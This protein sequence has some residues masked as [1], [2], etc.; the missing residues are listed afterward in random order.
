MKRKLSALLA[1][2]L[3]VV[4]VFP[5]AVFVGAEE[6]A[7]TAKSGDKLVASGDTIQVPVNGTV[8]LTLNVPENYEVS[9]SEKNNGASVA[10]GS[11]ERYT[12]GVLILN[13]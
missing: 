11:G 6:P 2:V 10:S 12:L 3:A 13:A 4:M 9:M 8:E 7:I 5:T 1:I